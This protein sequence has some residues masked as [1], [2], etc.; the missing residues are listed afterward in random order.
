M[1]FTATDVLVHAPFDS[2]SISQK[3]CNTQRKGQVKEQEQ[4]DASIKPNPSVTDVNIIR[5]PLLRKSYLVR[6]LQMSTIQTNISSK[7]F[8]IPETHGNAN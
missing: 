8:R 3:K 5:V 6:F 4:G 7:S 1:R 2:S